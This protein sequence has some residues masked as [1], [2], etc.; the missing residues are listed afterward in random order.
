M[1]NLL[2]ALPIGDTYTSTSY[3]YCAEDNTYTPSSS[4][5]RAWACAMRSRL[6]ERPLG[7]LFAEMFG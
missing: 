3:T 7:D 1:A 4:T 5:R 6:P 2:N